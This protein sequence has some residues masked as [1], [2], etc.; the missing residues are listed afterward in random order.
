MFAFG[1]GKEGGEGKGGKS[2]LAGKGSHQKMGKNRTA[3][4]NRIIVRVPTV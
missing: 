3:P 2:V 4:S 1:L